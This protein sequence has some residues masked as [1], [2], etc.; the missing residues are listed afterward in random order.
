MHRAYVTCVCIY[1]RGCSWHT[2]HG[3]PIGNHYDTWRALVYSRLYIYSYLCIY[4]WMYSF[5]YL[6]RYAYM[7]VYTDIYKLMYNCLFIEKNVCSS[8]WGGGK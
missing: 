2:P 4:I 8:I 3:Q 7:Y 6:F 1:K 5:I